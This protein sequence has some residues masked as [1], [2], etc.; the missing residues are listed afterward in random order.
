VADMRL[1][2][3]PIVFVNRAIAQD[4]GYRPEEMLGQGISALV[5]SPENA[6]TLADVEN[7]MRRGVSIRAE[8]RVRRRDGS[9][10]W[11]GVNLSPMRNSAGVPTHYVSV[12]ADITAKLEEAENRAR[13]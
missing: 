2:G 13:L 12:G 3:W 9:R 6:A 5:S 11:M 7:A 4:T 8:L 10:F 1:P